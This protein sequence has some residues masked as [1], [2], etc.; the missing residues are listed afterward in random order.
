MILEIR[1]D[2]YESELFE[3][4]KRKVSN[5]IFIDEDEEEKKFTWSRREAVET[6]GSSMHGRNTL[7]DGRVE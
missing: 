4:T 5:G 3:E 6:V 1:W 7:T 2:G